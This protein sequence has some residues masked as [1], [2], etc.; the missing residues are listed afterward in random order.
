MSATSILPAFCEVVKRPIYASQRNTIKHSTV[1][2]NDVKR[3]IAYIIRTCR[4]A[5]GA[6][7]RPYSAKVRTLIE[8][9]HDRAN[10]EQLA[11]RSMVISMLIRRAGG[12]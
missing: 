10:I 3:S 9:L 2:R 6:E 5:F 11:R 7:A 8:C 4:P 12:L 1:T